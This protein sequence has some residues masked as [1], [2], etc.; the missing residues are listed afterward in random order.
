[1][2]S[3]ELRGVVEARPRQDG[4]VVCLTELPDPLDVSGQQAAVLEALMDLVPEK[5]GDCARG[6][7][8][9]GLDESYEERVVESYGRGTLLHGSRSPVSVEL[10]GRDMIPAWLL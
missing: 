2:L 10:R 3:D 8:H 6:A 1:M 9:A 4:V 7:D 5:L